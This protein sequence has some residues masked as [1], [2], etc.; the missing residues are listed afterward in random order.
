MAIYTYYCMEF[1]T[2]I[3]TTSR[4]ATVE[5]IKFMYIRMN[6][7]LCMPIKYTYFSIW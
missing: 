7:E 4:D 3:A 1:K 6:I 2:Y 5:A